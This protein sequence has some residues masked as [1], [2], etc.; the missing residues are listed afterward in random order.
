M[1]VRAESAMGALVTVEVPAS[2]RAVGH[3]IVLAF[4]WFRQIESRCSRFDEESELHL[5]ARELASL[6]DFAV[7]AGGDL[8]LGGP[9]ALGS[10]WPVR[11]PHPRI[12]GEQIA[13]VPDMNRAVCTSADCER[14]PRTGDSPLGV[15]SVTLMAPQ[16]VLADALATV[17]LVLGSQA[18]I[19]LFESQNVE[20]LIVTAAMEQFGTRGF[21]HGA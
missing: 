18:G 10:P 12:Q 21:R 6:R 20:R 16:T 8:C 3:A 4:S 7:D 9:N 5:A 15:A 17:A 13:A 11:I 19:E 14:R 1:P 2:G